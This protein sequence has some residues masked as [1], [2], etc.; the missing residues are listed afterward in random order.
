MAAPVGL[1][2][3]QVID[4]AVAVL[5]ESGRV[6]A[7]ALRTVAERL[8]VRTQ[9]LYAHVDGLE[10]LR[11]A[12]ALR[13]L[14]ELADRLT[15]AAVGRAGADAVDAVVR[16]YLRFAGDH[17]GLYEV[18]LRAPAGDPELIAAMNAVMRPLNLVF[19]SYGLDETQALH[20]YRIV[21]AAVHG[22]A[23]LRRDGLITRPGDIEETVDRLSA[24]LTAQIEAEVRPAVATVGSVGSR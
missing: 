4:A 17:P 10:G 9:S 19:A 13:A 21:F 15:E 12:L 24:A 18:G 22:L 11:R 3:V 14:A 8:G 5:E 2:R 23:T 20:W 6:D 1:K 7:V 16:A